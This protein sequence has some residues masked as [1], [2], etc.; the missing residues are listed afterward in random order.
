MGEGFISFLHGK[1]KW[2]DAL[3]KSKVQA[4]RVIQF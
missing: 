2:I 3:G 4:N 1:R